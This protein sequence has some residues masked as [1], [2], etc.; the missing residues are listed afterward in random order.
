MDNTSFVDWRPGDCC[1]CCA[2]SLIPFLRG[3]VP[4]DFSSAAINLFSGIV[5]ADAVAPRSDN[6]ITLNTSEHSFEK[7]AP[8]TTYGG[9]HFVK[10]PSDREAFADLMRE[11]GVTLLAANDQFS[12]DLMDEFDEEGSLIITVLIGRNPLWNIQNLLYARGID[13]AIIPSDI[14]AS[15]RIRGIERIAERVTYITKL[16]DEEV[17]V[18]ARSD[19]KTIKDLDAMRVSIGDEASGLTQTEGTFIRPT[20]S[21]ISSAGFVHRKGLGSRLCSSM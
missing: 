12:R 11:R 17:H 2:A 21:M 19:I 15:S 3:E 6:E 5:G 16:Y 1:N 10:T 7:A 8:L 9:R 18:L 13:L 20:F 14:L 4:E